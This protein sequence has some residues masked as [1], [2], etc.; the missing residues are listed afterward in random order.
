MKQMRKSFGKVLVQTSSE[1]GNHTIVFGT[2]VLMFKRVKMCSQDEPVGQIKNLLGVKKILEGPQAI[3]EKAFAKRS[4]SV[5]TS[6]QN[7]GTKFCSSAYHIRCPWSRFTWVLSDRFVPA[8]SARLALLFD[9][10]STSTFRLCRISGTGSGVGSGLGGRFG[11][12]GATCVKA[13]KISESSTVSSRSSDGT[14]SRDDA[15][16]SNSDASLPNNQLED[17]RFFTGCRADFRVADLLNKREESTEVI[18]KFGI[19][20]GA[21]PKLFPPGIRGVETSF[22]KTEST[23]GLPSLGTD[24]YALGHL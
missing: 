21:S 23:R 11:G 10:G 16:V 13:S 22:E 1:K 17:L 4:G 12:S 7:G 8:V 6:V 9:V 5:K 14:V 3:F 24:C 19:L 15:L 18:F 2:V 20:R